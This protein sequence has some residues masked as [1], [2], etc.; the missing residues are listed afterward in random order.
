MREEKK[1][2]KTLKTLDRDLTKFQQEHSGILKNAKLCNNVIGE[3]LF[4]V[5]LDQVREKFQ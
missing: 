4:N 5:P 3:R 1:D 2:T